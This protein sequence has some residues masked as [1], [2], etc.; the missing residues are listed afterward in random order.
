MSLRSTKALALGFVM[1][2]AWGVIAPAAAADDVID[3]CIDQASPTADFDRAVANAVGER[4]D[5][6]V[7]IET[8]DGTGDDESGFAP[9][10]FVNLAE[11]RCDV[12]MGFPVA[13]EQPRAPDSLEMTEAYLDT[14]YV[15]VTRDAARPTLAELPAGERVAVAFQTP[16]NLLLLDRPKLKPVVVDHDEDGLKSVLDGNAAGALVWEANLR[17]AQDNSAK[18]RSLH[19]RP[20]TQSRG[21]W[22]LVALYSPANAATGERFNAAL[23]QVRADS[24]TWKGLHERV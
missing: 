19:F 21:K 20:V 9:G 6:P 22:S 1:A 5:N 10:N 18:V 13:H 24:G 12:I 11:T 7:A 2:A 3:V 8:F 23:Q 15:L 4:L 14:G 17:R 16:A